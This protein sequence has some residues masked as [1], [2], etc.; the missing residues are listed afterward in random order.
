MAKLETSFKPKLL[1]QVSPSHLLVASGN[2]ILEMAMIKIEGAAASFVK[3]PSA[4]SLSKVLRDQ[5][6]SKNAKAQPKPAGI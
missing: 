5:V 1:A 6:V 2:S 3:G 4:A